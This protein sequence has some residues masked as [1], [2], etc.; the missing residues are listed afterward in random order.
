MEQLAGL[1]LTPEAG[2]TLCRSRRRIRGR[3]RPRAAS[4]VPAIVR[5]CAERGW[6]LHPVSGGRNWGMGS[7][8]P[9]R[10]DCVLLDLSGLKAIGP[11]DRAT[12]TVRIEAGVTQRELHEWLRR[13]APELAFN[14]TGAGGVTS[15]VGNALERGL[16]YTGSRT[17]ELFGMEA[18]LADGSEH[19]PPEEWFSP[20]GVIPAGPQVEALFAQSGLAVVTAGRL[21]LRPRQEVEA[22]VVASGPAEAV[23]ATVAAAYRHNLFSQPVHMGGGGRIDDLGR[24]FLRAQW[25]REPTLEEVRRVFPLSAGHSALGALHGRGRVVRATIA[26]LRRLAAPGVRVR[27]AT[28]ARFRLAER[29]CR[30]LGLRDRAD[31]FAALRPLFA[32]AWGEPTD[33]GLAGLGLAPGEDDPDRAPRGCLYFNAVSAPA[34][35]ASAE[36]E[37]VCAAAWPEWSLTRVF[38][39]GRELVH[40]MSWAFD[41]ADAPRAHAAARALGETLRRRGFPP[42]RLSQATMTPVSS[43][44]ARAVKAAL[45][46]HGLLAP[47]HYP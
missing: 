23:F 25:G 17:G 47:G 10:D 33:A 30:R 38:L 29:W 20:T 24:G 7:F 28:D 9:D 45:D 16:G 37:R 19:R 35:E 8:L 21:K 6:P 1:P 18:V 4:E 27:V 15:I 42:Y 44:A 11:L 34:W 26:E 39:S 5:A 41:D 36:I 32:L 2:P 46:P 22:A 3:V 14:V 31:F 40:V 12:A 43:A 13:E